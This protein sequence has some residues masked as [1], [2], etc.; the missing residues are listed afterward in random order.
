MNAP[1][2]DK[3]VAWIWGIAEDVLSIEAKAEELPVGTRP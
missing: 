1:A 3:A 2:R